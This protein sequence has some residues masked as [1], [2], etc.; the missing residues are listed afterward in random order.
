VPRRRAA[1]YRL[2]DQRAAIISQLE[3]ITVS[4]ET[5]PTPRTTSVSKPAVAAHPAPGSE[6]VVPLSRYKATFGVDKQTT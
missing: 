5:R 1:G 6:P 2:G 4:E 3:S